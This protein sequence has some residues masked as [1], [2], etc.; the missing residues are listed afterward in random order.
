M[1]IGIGTDL[2]EKERVKKACEKDAFLSYVFTEAEIELI[3]K[4]ADSAASNWAVKEAVAKAMGTGF[5]GMKIK[6]IEVLRDDFGKPYIK[7]YGKALEKQKALKIERF[8]VSIS[9]TKEYTTAV[10]VAEG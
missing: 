2:I 3:R 9:D 6:E 7:L 8:F 4:K 1:I 10:V 5:L